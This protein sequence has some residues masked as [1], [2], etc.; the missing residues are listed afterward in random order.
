MS[1][2]DS[3]GKEIKSFIKCD[4]SVSYD[5]VFFSLSALFVIHYCSRNETSGGI[6]F[7]FVKTK[8]NPRRRRNRTAPTLIGYR[9]EACTPHQ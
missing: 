1:Y 6:F 5:P 4:F 8:Q 9:F 3:H 2:S 7:I